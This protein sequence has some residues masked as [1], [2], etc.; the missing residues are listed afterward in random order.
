MTGIS[1]T[2]TIC[3]MSEMV[4]DKRKR[5]LTDDQVGFL[6]AWTLFA[7]VTCYDREVFLSLFV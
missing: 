4:Q 2:L 7:F 6:R 5:G 3:N 1:T